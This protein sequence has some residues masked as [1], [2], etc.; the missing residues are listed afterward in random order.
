[1]V[2][3]TA[4]ITLKNGPV[5]QTN[6]DSYQMIRMNEAPARTNRRATLSAS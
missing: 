4:I 3:H 2:F 5:E 1:V 6:F